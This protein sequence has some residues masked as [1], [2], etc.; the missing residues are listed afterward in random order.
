MFK[1]VAQEVTLNLRKQPASNYSLGKVLVTE[2][3]MSFTCC[4]Y[5]YFI[6]LNWVVLFRYFAECFLKTSRRQT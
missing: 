2:I 6:I 1:N 3:Y 4:I 5:K